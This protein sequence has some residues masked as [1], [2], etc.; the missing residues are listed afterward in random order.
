MYNELSRLEGCDLLKILVDDTKLNL[1]LEKKKQFIGNKVVWDSVLSSL[2][3]LVSVFFASYDDIF[4]VSGYVLKTVFVLLGLFFSGKSI[5][6]VWCSKKNSYTH[7]DLFK[8]INKL[9]EITHNHSIIAMKDSFNEFPNRFLL[10]YDS[11]WSCYLFMN[12]KENINNESF[13]ISGISN[14]LKVKSDDI[15]VKYIAQQIHEKYSESHKENR[16]YCHRLFTVQISG[17]PD[18]IRSDH[19]TIDGVNY[20]WMSISE[21]EQDSRIMHVNNDVVQFVKNNCS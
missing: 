10:Y 19:F 13:I 4:F 17:W 12:F 21:M 14:K 16:I 1:L 6:D 5:F 15:T 7:N 2:S 3:F 9:N 11:R 18:I 20:Q 8:D